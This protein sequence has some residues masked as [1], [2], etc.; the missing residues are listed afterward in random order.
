MNQGASSVFLSP[1]PAAFSLTNV[2]IWLKVYRFPLGSG[3]HILY[4]RTPGVRW[5]V[6]NGNKLDLWKCG[7]SFKAHCSLIGREKEEHKF[8]YLGNMSCLCIQSVLYIVLYTQVKVLSIYMFSR[9]EV[10]EFWNLKALEREHISWWVILENPLLLN[11]ISRNRFS[12]HFY[13][14][15]TILCRLSVI[16]PFGWLGTSLQWHRLGAQWT[17]DWW[18]RLAKS[19][20]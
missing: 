6:Q 20:E 15:L 10:T 8:I 18:I 16:L 4:T 13:L 2:D 12:S 5:R 9:T 3:A 14:C 7:T 1:L 19:L 17:P 11:S